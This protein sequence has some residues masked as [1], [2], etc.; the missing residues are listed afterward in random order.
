MAK[1]LI[2]I[3][4]QVLAEV[5]ELLGTATKKDTVDAALRKVLTD[6]RRA[7][8]LDWLIRHSREGDFEEILDPAREAEAWQ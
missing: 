8:S 1:T 4:D 5:A 7:E 6:Q 3:D 2:D